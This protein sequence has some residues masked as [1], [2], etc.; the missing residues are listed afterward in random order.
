MAKALPVYAVSAQG[1]LAENAPLILHTRL[2]E[3][4]RF[5]PYIADPSKVDELHNMCIAAKRLRYTMEIFAPCIRSKEFEALYN[6]VK[7]IQEQ[8]GEIHDAD[9]RGPLLQGF[10]DKRRADRPEIGAGLEAVIRSQQAQRAS[11]YRAFV[12]YWNKLQRQ[13]FKGRFL[14]MLVNVETQ[15]SETQTPGEEMRDDEQSDTDQ[16]QEVGQAQGEDVPA[17][18]GHRAG[19]AAGRGARRRGGPDPPGG[20]R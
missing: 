2:E 13:G 16:A 1:P 20:E 9:V 6:Q 5:A 15:T 3:M 11:G 19:P 4:Y 12:A 18:A 8:I 7:S 17:L 10:L 14:Q